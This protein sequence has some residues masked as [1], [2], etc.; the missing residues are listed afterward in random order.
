MPEL[1]IVNF[2]DAALPKSMAKAL[3]Q[4]RPGL[5]PGVGNWVGVGC[6]VTVES[7]VGS[8]ARVAVGLGV[9][10]ALEGATIAGDSSTSAPAQAQRHQ[11]TDGQDA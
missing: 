6:G 2:E 7:E 3:L 11:G 10:V 4:S 5:G 8:G 1:G 9:V